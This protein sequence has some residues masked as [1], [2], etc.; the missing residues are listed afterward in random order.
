MAFIYLENQGDF[1]FEE[2]IIE[3]VDFGRWFLMDKGDIDGDGDLDLMV[4]SFSYVFS[5]VPQQVQNVWKEK[6]V[7]LLIL[8]NTL[9]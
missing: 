6:D 3:Q 9:R 1:Q 7:D 5:P 2:R 4:S 8:E